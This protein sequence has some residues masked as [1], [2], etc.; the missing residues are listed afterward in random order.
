MPLRVPF[1][2]TLGLRRRARRDASEPCSRVQGG[3]GLEERERK[4][5]V[6]EE[7][8]SDPSLLTF[9]WVRCKYK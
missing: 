8:R 1:G 4:D 2:P 6:K 5:R 3:A 7:G 9:P